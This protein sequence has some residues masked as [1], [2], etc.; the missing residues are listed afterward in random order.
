VPPPE[1]AEQNSGVEAAEPTTD[2]VAPQQHSAVKSKNMET[3]V[4]L[5][6]EET[7]KEITRW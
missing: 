1:T 5:Q 6:D 2:D 3:R 7:I 4:A